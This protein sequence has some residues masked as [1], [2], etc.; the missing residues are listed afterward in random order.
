MPAKYNTISYSKLNASKDITLSEL[1]AND[2]VKSQNMSYAKS[3]GKQFQL[4]TPKI[5]FDYAGIPSHDST[6][7]P[8][9]LDKCKGTRIPL[10]VNPIDK[11]NNETDE[12][13]NLRKDKM[14]K[15]LKCL[16]SI[17]KWM[18]TDEVKKTLFGSVAKAKKFKYDNSVRYPPGHDDSDDD[19]EG[20]PEGIKKY[21]KGPYLNV[22]LPS[23][24]GSD[25]LDVDVYIEDTDKD[26]KSPER[27]E[28]KEVKSLPELRKYMGY[29]RKVRLGLH[30]CKV[31][32]HKKTPSDGQK[33]YALGWKIKKVI[34]DKKDLMM[35]KKDNE[36]D[37]N[38]IDDILVD[39][40]DDEM[41]N[42]VVK[43]YMAED[44]EDDSSSDE[45][46]EEPV[47][48]KKKRGGRKK[49]SS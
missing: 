31:W 18:K 44:D 19:S 35:S 16:N 17:D 29:M 11:P 36:D 32:C 20:N 13:F 10:V 22:K 2:R 7:H 12:E 39:S 6:Y 47:V 28:K 25:E 27:F 5:T 26:K 45:S 33:K 4:Q 43:N 23:V 40:D 3:N 46:S 24:W 14:E 49:K 34:V 8:T 37:E 41:E 21:F 30:L 9:F 42:A 38:D 15:F 48:V 1:E